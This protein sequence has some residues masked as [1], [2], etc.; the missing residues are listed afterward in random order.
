MKN[1]IET[2]L[3]NAALCCEKEDP[4]AVIVAIFCKKGVVTFHSVDMNSAQR[5]VLAGTVFG[6]A[7]VDQQKERLNSVAIT[8]P[9]DKVVH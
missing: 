1:S 3:A 2:T 4:E 6:A 7:I 5:M 8:T 9:E